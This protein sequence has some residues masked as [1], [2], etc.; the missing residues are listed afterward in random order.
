[1]LSLLHAYS[2]GYSSLSLAARVS[3]AASQ[4]HLLLPWPR[5][6]PG[7]T[8][9]MLVARPF[10]FLFDFLCFHSC[11]RPYLC[12]LYLFNVPLAA[13]ACICIY[14]FIF[15]LVNVCHVCH[16]GPFSQLLLTSSKYPWQSSEQ[17]RQDRMLKHFLPL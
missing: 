2:A 13:A 15:V 4:S 1:M 9:I 6:G 17:M 12:L 7:G 14:L 11:C 10:C 16:P 8:R 5:C 3:L